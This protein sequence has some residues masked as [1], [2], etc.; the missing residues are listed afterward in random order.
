[1]KTS[2][3]RAAILLGQKLKPERDEHQPRRGAK[4]STYES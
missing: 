2:I 3:R 4:E 1:L